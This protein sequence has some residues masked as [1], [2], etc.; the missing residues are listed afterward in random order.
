[1]NNWICPKCNAQNTA[2]FCMNCGAPANEQSAPDLPPTV[3]G[4]Q[5][6]IVP[7]QQNFAPNQPAQTPPHFQQQPNFQPPP[8]SSSGKKIALIG[9]IIGL[10][11]VI[12]GGIALWFAVISPYFKE[13][14]RLKKEYENGLLAKLTPAKDLLP[15]EFTNSVQMTFR[16]G[17]IIDKMQLLQASQNLPP[18]LKS[19]VNN[20]NDAAGAEYVSTTDSN[21]KVVLQILKYNS[22]EQAVAVCDKIGR[23]L[24][25]SKASLQEV[26]Y[27]PATLN[28]ETNCHTSG[29]DKKGGYTGV[30]TLYGFMM[31]VVGQKDSK[32]GAVTY[33]VFKKLER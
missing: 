29:A 28:R 24:E 18:E 32:P 6:P 2:N 1:M 26:V 4:F 27:N 16:K 25:K 14:A 31:I 22:P 23:E 3:V 15:E 21:R 12:A 7:N 20:I 17:K 9:G 11:V 5:P 30:S 13:Q 10:V 19:E 8:Q 33:E